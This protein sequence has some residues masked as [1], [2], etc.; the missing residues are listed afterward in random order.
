MERS[1]KARKA[2]LML[3][4]YLSPSHIL[5]CNQKTTKEEIVNLLLDKIC[6]LSDLAEPQAIKNAVWEREREG[7]TVLENGL[8]IPHAR[9]PNLKELKACLA[10]LPEGYIDPV[11]K[12]AV[13]E[14]FL[15]LSP[16]EQF[17]THLQMLA[18]ISRVFQNTDFIN[19][20][21][22]SKDS[23]DAF[24]LIQRQERL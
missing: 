10:I 21:L 8:A 17:E 11:E 2:P 5:L 19:D 4:H 12:I 24:T 9:I 20:L 15:F 22:G 13:K 18:K 16:L 7:R 23:E 14:V 1:Q 6:E 3:C